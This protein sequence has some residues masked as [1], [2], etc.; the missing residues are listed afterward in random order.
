MQPSGSETKIM[1]QRRMIQFL[2]RGVFLCLGIF[3]LWRMVSEV[4]TVEETTESSIR[5]L[6]NSSINKL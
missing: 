6:H 5:V 1:S 3:L 2:M 4:T